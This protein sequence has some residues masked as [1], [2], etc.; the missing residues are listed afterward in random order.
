MT[1]EIIN[2]LWRIKDT[3]AR[4]Y[5]Y[6]LD[7]LVAYLRSKER[8]GDYHVTDPRSARV[9]RNS[10]ADSAVWERRETEDVGQ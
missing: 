10:E 4:D 5:G 8:A 6:D 2:E 9:G 7:A 1:D 3:I